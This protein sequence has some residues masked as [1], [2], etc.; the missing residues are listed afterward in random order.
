MR[1]KELKRDSVK[2]YGWVNSGVALIFAIGIVLVLFVITTGLLVIFGQWEKSSFLLFSRTHSIHA[3]KI[4]IEQAIWELKNDKN[5]YDGYDEQ[6]HAKFAGTD[7]DID[8][9]GIKES[10]FFPVKNF[11]GKIVARYAVLVTDE[12]GSININYVGNISKNGKHSFNEGW[13]TFEIRL[14]PDTCDN[15]ADDIVLFRMGKDCASGIKDIDDDNDNSILSNDGIDNDGDG[16]IDE[17]NEGIDEPDEFNHAKPS[18]DDRPFFVI[19]DLKMARGMTDKLFN[20]IKNYITTYSYDLN[21][22][23]ENY[24]RTNINQATLSQIVSILAGLGYE[25]DQ[26]TQIGVNIL[27]YRDKDNI[28][29]VIKTPD[30]KRFIGLEKT[31]YINEIEPMPE[32][33]IDK[34]FTKTGIPVVIL[35]ELGPNFIEI[36]NPYDQPID[37]GG[38]SIKGGLVLLPSFD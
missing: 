34:T 29:T 24:L 31:P 11:R 33:R 16:I 8:Q 4:G 37:I 5:N 9:D 21:I 38:W 12:S 3:A 10:Q 23:A 18:G 25:K 13:T 28:P 19:E 27:D 26:A 1:E 20:R 35:E 7:I 36:V 17:E 32:L 30:G 6:W 2:R 14:F 15:V 22:D